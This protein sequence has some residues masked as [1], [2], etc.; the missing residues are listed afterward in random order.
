MPGE[1]PSVPVAVLLDYD[2]T[3]SIRDVGD[4]LMTRFVAD[5]D[6]AKKWD[7]PTSPPTNS[8]RGGSGT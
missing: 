7:V 5:R 2:G 4:D 1:Q 6:K 8:E 3:I